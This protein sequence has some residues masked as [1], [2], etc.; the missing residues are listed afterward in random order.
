MHADCIAKPYPPP[1]HPPLPGAIDT[2]I[3]PTNRPKRDYQFEIVQ[4]CFT[5]NC[6]VALPTGLGKTFVAGVVM[7]NC[8]YHMLLWLEKLSEKG[9][10]RGME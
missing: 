1:K 7:L 6:L 10:G 3:Y 4:A 8:T 9:T 5:D 2:Y